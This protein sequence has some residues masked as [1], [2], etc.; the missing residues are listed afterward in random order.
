MSTIGTGVLTLEDLSKRMTSDL[1]IA[2]IIELTAKRNEMLTDMLWM[3]GNLLIGHKTTIRTGLPTPTWRQLNYGVVQTKST[4][5]QITDTCGMLEAFSKI[6]A[7]LA[8][9]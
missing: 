9:L 4:T 7:A 1:G 8:E 5:A 6:D 3:E 2:K